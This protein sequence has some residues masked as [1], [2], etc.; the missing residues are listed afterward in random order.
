[1]AGSNQRYLID[2]A[3]MF[4]L[5]GILIFMIL[6][7]K[8]KSVEA[9][10]ILEKMFGIITVFT[11]FVGIGC[12]IIGEHDYFEYFSKEEYYKTRYT[13]CFWE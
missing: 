9:K 5:A 8:L 3:W 7:E 1:M 4:I 12:G 2:Y 6:L 13:I 10:R 11:F